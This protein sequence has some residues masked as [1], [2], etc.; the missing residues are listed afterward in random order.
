MKKYAKF[1]YWCAMV[2]LVGVFLFSA[3]MIFRYVIDAKKSEESFEE[4]A[5][6]MPEIPP[7]KDETP[8]TA[9]ETYA[10]VL[11]QNDDFVGWLKIDGTKIDYPVLQT[12]DHKNY[13]L[14]RGFDKKYSYYGVP[15][16]AEYCKI[17]ESDNL[18]I[19]GHNMNNGS[20]F[21]DLT[22]YADPSFYKEH[23]YIQF[24]TMESFGAYEIIA[25]FKTTAYAEG[26]FEYF[27]FVEGDQSAFDQFVSTCKG[28]SLYDIEATA[29]YGDRLI[30]LSTCEYSR[31]NGRFVVVA[32][33]INEKE[34]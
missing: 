13:Y 18:V 8:P 5:T 11:A 22:K 1:F 14:R 33:R 31:K 4:L 21:Y 15:Y 28:L 12:P 26:E 3:F 6:L 16:M 30:T 20:M 32:K 27:R 7:E 9:A 2:V 17:N 23:R 25:V 29:E 34:D 10:P 19:Y 24:D